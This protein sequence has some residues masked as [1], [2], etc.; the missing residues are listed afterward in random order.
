MALG[1]L[2]HIGNGLEDALQDGFIRGLHC[3]PVIECPCACA[4]L[5]Q[6]E[7]V[8]GLIRQV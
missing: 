6:C 4:E 7:S 2:I 5:T 3:L 1:H 8:R